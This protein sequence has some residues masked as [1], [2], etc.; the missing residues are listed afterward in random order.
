M[1]I[2]QNNYWKIPLKKPKIGY[3]IND[4][5]VNKI[6]L[7][8]IDNY[9]KVGNPN[10]LNVKYL[11]FSYETNSTAEGKILVNNIYLSDPAILRGNA[12]RGTMSTNL[13]G[14]GALTGNYSVKTSNF[15]PLGVNRSGYDTTNFSS[16]LQISKL[17]WMPIS[18]GYSKSISN[19]KSII[20]YSSTSSNTRNENQTMRVSTNLNLNQILGKLFPSI[21]YSYSNSQ[22]DTF[23]NL[24]DLEKKK[25]TSLNEAHTFAMRLQSFLFLFRSLNISGARNIN[26]SKYNPDFDNT[27]TNKTTLRNNV[28]ANFTIR[29][30]NLLNSFNY[31]D[32][33]ENDFKQTDN[34]TYSASSNVSLIK[35]LV[36]PNLKITGKLNRIY[37]KDNT[38]SDISATN[39]K[40]STSIRLTNRISFSRLFRK[41]HFM[42]VNS[43]NI[44][45]TYNKNNDSTIGTYK[46]IFPINGVIDILGNKFDEQ[47]YTS[48]TNRD[49]LNLSF[50]YSPF[51]FIGLSGNYSLNISNTKNMGT[52]LATTTKS[53]NGNATIMK[54]DRLIKFLHRTTL[55]LGM[56]YRLNQSANSDLIQKTYNPSLSFPIYFSNKFS[57]SLRVSLSRNMQT[58]FGIETTTTDNLTLTSNWKYTLMLQYGIKI[59][60]IKKK[61]KLKNA[62]NTNF[63]I[64]Y[65][66][67]RS[68][69]VNSNESNSFSINGGFDYRISRYFVLN[70]NLMYKIY[71]DITVV[72]RDYNEFK[73]TVGGNIIF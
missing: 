47:L 16:S 10:L 68:D 67:I 14:L 57:Q 35:A 32:S 17:R 48:L 40:F 42:G 4:W 50:N 65:A 36:E 1:G 12:Y 41:F 9:T 3:N 46:N 11:G 27:I 7:N 2:D 45:I 8:N 25:A 54:I 5:Y 15:S 24:D 23:G 22:N 64:S 70:S 37:T 19:L 28:G 53:I 55:T 44:N 52:I 13:L 39:V 6:D 20:N 56:G 21:S 62:V 34:I 49:T 58:R 66:L 60:F 59:P 26:V 61:L 30:L 72:S 51:T 73:F 43:I 31:N 33:Y 18:I 38:S 63:G 29:F 69:V 71:K